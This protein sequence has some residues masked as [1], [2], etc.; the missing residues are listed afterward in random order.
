MVVAIRRSTVR[1]ASARAPTRQYRRCLMTRRWLMMLTVLTLVVAPVIPVRASVISP[2][3]YAPNS[4]QGRVQSPG[5]AGAWQAEYY[6]NR[7]LRGE[8]VL[9]RDDPTIDFRWGH[10]SPGPEVPAD[11]FSVRWTRTVTLEPGTYRFTVTADDGVRLR[12]NGQPVI[13]SWVDQPLTAHSGTVY[14]SGDAHVELEYYENREVAAVALAWQPEPATRVEGAVEAVLAYWSAV[15]E[16]EYAR[17]YRLWADG[18]AR[19]GQTLEAFTAGF[20]DTVEITVLLGRVDE[21]DDGSVTVPVTLMAVANVPGSPTRP[22]R[23]QL[24]RG[25]YTLRAIGGTWR[26]AGARIVE[27]SPHT[28]LPREVSNPLALLRGYFEA[29]NSGELGRAYTSWGRIGEASVQSFAAFRAGFE[30]TKGVEVYYG[31]PEEGAA[32]GSVYARVPVVIMA[33]EPGG[34]RRAFCG[35]YT[36]RRANVPPFDRFGWRIDRADIVEVDPVPVDREALERL[37]GGGCG[38]QARALER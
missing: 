30:V 12:V 34:M 37:L 14:V 26:I 20:A 27:V 17:A 24:Y 38:A 4:W 13:D 3:G 16:R 25:T 6:A 22:Q 2:E 32:A 29:I 35:S 18:G 5:E 28:A 10:G 9:R 19:S 23:L 31:E 36:L 33:D 11:G 21:R 1:Y 7:S 15:N 8:P